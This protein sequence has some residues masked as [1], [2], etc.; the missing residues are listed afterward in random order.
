[1]TTEIFRRPAAAGEP[2]PTRPLFSC[3]CPTYRRPAGLLA[4]AVACFLAQTYTPRELIVLADDNRPDQQ[5]HR[6]R[7]INACPRFPTL[8]AK[9][10]ALLSMAAGDLVAVWED[11]DTYLPN[12]LETMAAALAGHSWA[13]PAR[14]LSNYS[15]P[16]PGQVHEEPAAG[17]FH[18]ALGFRADFLRRLGGW[19]ATPRADFDQ[20]L[21]ARAQEAAT[22]GDPCQFT[23]HPTYVFRWQTGAGHGQLNMKGADDR[24]WYDRVA[25]NWPELDE[26]PQPIT[27]ALDPASL[28][29]YRRHGWSAD[30]DNPTYRRAA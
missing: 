7:I 4:N 27:P 13:H 2:L 14:V 11:D 12:H 25:Q 6:W 1:M 10:N 21:I 18:A 19:P 20:Q 16:D 5:G 8:P 22:R 9:Y 24:R 28:E 26:A 23:S 29:I 3:L 30:K 15:E 17:R